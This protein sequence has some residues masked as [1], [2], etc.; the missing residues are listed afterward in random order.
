MRNQSFILQ[1]ECTLVPLEFAKYIL[2]IKSVIVIIAIVSV[3]I[4]VVVLASSSFPFC[5]PCSISLVVQ[6]ADT[7]SRK[8]GLD[9]TLSHG[10]Q[11]ALVSHASNTSKKR[12]ATAID[13]P[14]LINKANEVPAAKIARKL[15]NARS[16]FSSLT[17]R[18]D[19]HQ[20]GASNGAT[21][22]AGVRIGVL[23]IKQMSHKQY[24]SDSNNSNDNRTTT[25]NMKDC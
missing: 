4:V 19:D 8:K 3:V 23:K 15:E 11:E 20:L 12:P 17:W 5:C 1:T 22:K 7:D 10:R 24:N 13:V 2:Q 25:R 21:R 14:N 6:D 16:S 18:K 9:R